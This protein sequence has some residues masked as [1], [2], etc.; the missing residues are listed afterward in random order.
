VRLL[1]AVDAHRTVHAVTSWL[2]VQRDGEIVGWNLDF[3]RRRSDAAKGVMEFLI[4]SAA[5]SCQAEGARFVSLS[6][7]PLARVGADER[8]HGVQRLLDALADRLE[9][10]YG[11]SSLL[12]FKAKFQ[13]EY[14]P[15]YMAYPDPVALPAIA[16]AL[17]RAYL[18]DLSPRQLTRLVRAILR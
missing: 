18:P 6:A 1:L 15:L 8:A 10:V 11:F 3:M 7:A 12:C 2:P 9:P 16:N 17:A 4:A 14:R 5:M 13:P